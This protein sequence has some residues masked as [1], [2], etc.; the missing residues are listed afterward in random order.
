[1]TESD[2]KDQRDDR[3]RTEHTSTEEREEPKLTPV[4]T[5]I[6]EDRDNLRRRRDWFQRRSGSGE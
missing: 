2:D 6:P 1:M 4:P 5:P 3:P